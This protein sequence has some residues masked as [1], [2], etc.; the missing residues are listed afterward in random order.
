MAMPMP[1][2]RSVPSPAARGVRS[3][4][5]TPVIVEGSL[6]GLMVVGSRSAEKPLPTGA[7]ARLASF[8]ELVAMAIANAESCSQRSPRRSGR[9]SARTSPGWAASIVMTR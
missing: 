3:A 7:E 6:W 2:A 8:T 5:G 9:C 1:L 4:A